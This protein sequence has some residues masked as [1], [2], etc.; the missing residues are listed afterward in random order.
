[1]NDFNTQIFGDGGAWE[2]IEV[3]A[4]FALVKV[5]ASATTLSTIANTFIR[6]PVSQLDTSLSLLTNAQ[7]N[8]IKNKI[9]EM[10]YTSQEITNALGSNMGTKTLRELLR[11]IATRRVKPRFDSVSKQIVFDGEVVI[12]G[13]TVEEVDGRVK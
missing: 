5:S 8:T 4:N 2:E 10:G 9:L 1:M 13:K 3:G 6:I 11:F 7:K 12:P